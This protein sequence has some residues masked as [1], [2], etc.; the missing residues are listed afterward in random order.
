MKPAQAPV[1]VEALSFEPVT[2]HG[3]SRKICCLLAT[4]GTCGPDLEPRFRRERREPVGVSIWDS[5]HTGLGLICS[6][7][8]LGY[9]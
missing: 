9:S 3:K 1:P 2:G 4:S 6:P 5:P 8:S 7:G